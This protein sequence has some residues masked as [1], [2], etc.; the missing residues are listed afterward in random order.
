MINVGQFSRTGV[1]AAPRK[2]ALRKRVQKLA[3]P[4]LKRRCV[5]HKWRAMN[6]EAFLKGAEHTRAAGKA[7]GVLHCK[8]PNFAPICRFCAVRLRKIV[9]FR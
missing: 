8:P 5:R 6:C 7:A 3:A 2:R 4:A 9:V 1:Y